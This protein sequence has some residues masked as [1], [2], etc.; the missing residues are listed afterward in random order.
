M[1]T[2]NPSH[3]PTPRTDANLYTNNTFYVEADFA[4]QLERELMEANEVLEPL[5][6]RSSKDGER[7]KEMFARAR[8]SPIYWMEIV[9]LCDDHIKHLQSQLTQYEDL[10]EELIEEL[11]ADSFR[12]IHKDNCQCGRCKLITRARCL[13]DSQTTEG[14][15]RI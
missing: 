1:T 6:I 9:E 8:K 3:T 11:T 15:D 13:L 5:K 10:I 2:L 14:K 7:F 4:R 12:Y